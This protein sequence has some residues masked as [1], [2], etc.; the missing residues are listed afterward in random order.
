MMGWVGQ[1][2]TSV[3]WDG[4]DCVSKNGSMSN[5]WS[6]VPVFN[7]W[8]LVNSSASKKIQQYDCG[9]TSHLEFNYLTYSMTIKRLVSFYVYA[10]IIPSVLLSFLMPL[11]FWIPPSGDG[12]ITLG[13]YFLHRGCFLPYFLSM[14]ACLFVCPLT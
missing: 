13:M 8:T 11:T 14:S 1:A 10:L 6:H 9:P 5:S 3:G 4:L 2:K 12:R 7:K